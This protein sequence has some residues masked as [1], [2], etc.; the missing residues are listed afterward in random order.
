VKLIITTKDGCVDSVTKAFTT[1]Y[2]QPKADFTSIP[3]KVCM[4]DTIRFM[5]NSNGITSVANTW[6]WDL[7]GGVTSAL[8]NPLK[9]FNDSGIFNIKLYFFNGQGCVSDTVTKQVTVYP[10]PKLTLGPGLKVLEGGEI[11]I[12]P[13]YYYGTSLSFLWTPSLYLDS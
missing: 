7:A 3:S 13:L 11:T 4:G 10:Y 9:K 1:I 8:Q 6:S 2:P 5:D 12:K